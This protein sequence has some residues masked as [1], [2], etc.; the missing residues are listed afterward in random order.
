MLAEHDR[1]IHNAK[2]RAFVERFAAKDKQ[3]IEYP[4]AHHTLEFEEPRTFVADVLG[5]LQSHLGEPL[6]RKRSEGATDEH[7]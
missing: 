7:G 2:T 4:G 6:V 3:V 5:W 1:I